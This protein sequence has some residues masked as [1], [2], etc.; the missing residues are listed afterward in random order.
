MISL[1]EGIKSAIISLSIAIF[2][3]YILLGKLGIQKYL[4]INSWYLKKN[5]DQ[6]QL[7]S[8][9]KWASSTSE[10]TLLSSHYIST[11]LLT[12]SFYQQKKG[13]WRFPLKLLLNFLYMFVVR[14]F[15]LLD[16]SF[17]SCWGWPHLFFVPKKFSF[18]RNLEWKITTF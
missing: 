1:F 12:F 15:Y 8:Q 7:A 3:K 5:S 9:Q 11:Y 14:H 18:A 2:S 16:G 13:K 4:V 6:T 17:Q 10:Y